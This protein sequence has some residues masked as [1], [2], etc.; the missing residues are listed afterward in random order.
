MNHN[1]HMNKF[2][3]FNAALGD[4]TFTY[5]SCEIQSPHNDCKKLHQV[6]KPEVIVFL[7]AQTY[8]NV[9]MRFEHL[10]LKK[11]RLV[12]RVDVRLYATLFFLFMPFA[13]M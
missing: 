4:E 10:W 2:S 9:Y 11:K 3:M 6:K 12:I 13:M 5:S 7:P 1:M 8:V